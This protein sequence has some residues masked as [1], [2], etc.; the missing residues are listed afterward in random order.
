MRKKTLTL[1]GIL[2]LALGSFASAGTYDWNGGAADG[3]WYNPANWTCSNTTWTFPTQQDTAYNY[4]TNTDCGPINIANGDAVRTGITGP[5]NC[6]LRNGGLAAPP[7]VLTLDNGSSW[8]STSTLWHPDAG[9]NITEVHVLNGST[10][11]ANEIRM[12]DNAGDISTT[13][14]NNGTI[15]TSGPFRVGHR[16]NAQAI[17]NITNGT[18]NVGGTLYQCDTSGGGMKSYITM[19]G[20]TMTIT[21]YHYIVDDGTAGAEG[22][23]TLL[24]G[25]VV[26]NGGTV[27]V[28]WAVTGDKSHLTINGGTYRMTDPAGTFYLGVGTGGVIES[29]V[30]MDGL[31]TLEIPNIAFNATDSK[32]V[33]TAGTLKVLSANL[34]EA[35]MQDLINTGKIEAGGG[36]QI[37]TDGNYTVLGRLPV[38]HIM[39][40]PMEL[41]VTEGGATDSY[42]VYFTAQ[43]DP[44]YEVTVTATPGDAQIDIGNGIGAA[45]T[46]TFTSVNWET[47]Q[48]I[49]VSA[50]DDEILERQD[51]PH[52]TIITHTSYSEDED[53]N[54]LTINSVEVLVHDNELTCGDWGYYQTDLNEDCYVNLRDYAMFALA[55]LKSNE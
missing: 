23:F 10:L 15:N 39:V 4:Y 36:Y 24:S 2:V 41:E 11:S 16:D 9:N 30:F 19:D 54:G 7:C 25:T 5:N 43:P 21:G 13:I 55:W 53:F 44:S 3:D 42:E 52:T 46:L 48:T 50:V 6:S 12:A 37:Y 27:T 31:G 22:Y 29:R 20:G 32:V 34:S 18:I 35:G 8:T 14:V 45:K 28:P 26:V 38:T 33:F 51:D 49:T 40:N 47:A 1:M 17:L